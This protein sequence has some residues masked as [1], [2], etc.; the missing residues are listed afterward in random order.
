M[1]IST[2]E[3][4]AERINHANK[5]HGLFDS[6]Q[7]PTPTAWDGTGGGERK[8]PTGQNHLRDAVK[9]PEV[10]GSLNPTWVEWLMGWHLGWT[11]LK[12]LAMDK[13]QAWQRSHGGL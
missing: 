13:F 6:K 8:T 9:T 12:P 10:G 3:H 7:W 1:K 2:I 4:L 5:T 11:D